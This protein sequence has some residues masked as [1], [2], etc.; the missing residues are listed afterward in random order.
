MRIGIDCRMFGLKF[1]GIGRCAYELV[2][3]LIATNEKLETPNEI[4]LFFNK[5]EYHEFPETKNVKKILVNAQHYSLKE[6]TKF[7]W[8]LYKEKL[9]V[10][11]FP[12]FNVPL[13]YRKKY[14]VTIHDLTLSLFPGNKMT[15]WY[16]RFA[17]HVVI[18]NVVK[19]AKKIIAVS[20]NTKKDIMEMLHVPEQKIKVIYNGVSSE[21]EMIE[22]VSKFKHTLAKY[23]ISKE[24]L[25]Y[26]GVW[27]SHKN[28]SRLVHAFSLVKHKYHLDLQLVITGKH[29]PH[30][31]EVRHAAKMLS[32]ENDIIFTGAVDE[33]ELV[34]LY[35][36]ALFYI[37]PSLYEGFG[38]PVLESMKCGTP[39]IASNISSIPEI[40]G[41]GNAVLFDPYNIDD[42]AKKIDT[43]YKDP[44]LQAELID[45][46]LRRA[47]EFSW[48]KMTAETYRLITNLK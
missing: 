26:T 36:A 48:E 44:K 37:L 9:D 41:E 19:T 17:Y 20:E 22:D 1:T 31:P 4:I 8:M 14:T 30:Y 21:F 39:V 28:L 47:K 18:R 27:R 38:L 2:Q 15:K 11:H 46:G 35:N 13:F 3:H 45:K 33:K 40:C 24:F 6:Q 34:H 42:I 29:D 32:L 23:K 10:V 12:H 7:A 16:Q 5:N 25:L 43:L